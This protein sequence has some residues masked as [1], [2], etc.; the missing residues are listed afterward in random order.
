MDKNYPKSFKFKPRFKVGELVEL[1]ISYMDAENYYLK[2]KIISKYI[3]G[4][5]ISAEIGSSHLKQSLEYLLS[6]IHPDDPRFDWEY[7]KNRYAEHD[8][9]FSEEEL[10]KVPIPIPID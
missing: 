10:S 5:R 7:L 4:L 9:Y 3:A 1:K 8:L 2:N 6:D